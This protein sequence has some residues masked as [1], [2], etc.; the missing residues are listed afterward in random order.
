MSIIDR[1]SNGIESQDLSI[2]KL[3]V[4]RK[5]GIVILINKWDTQNKE[6]NTARDIE[7]KIKNKLAPM[8]DVPVIFILHSKNN[9]F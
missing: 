7:E 3:A 4:D 9:A 6:T 5:K 2:F 8:N 1:C